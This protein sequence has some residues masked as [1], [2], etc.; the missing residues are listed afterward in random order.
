M[1]QNDYEHIILNDSEDLKQEFYIKSGKGKHAS[2]ELLL[3]TN[4]RIYFYGREKRLFM[5]SKV[6]RF[7]NLKAIYA[8]SRSKGR[9]SILLFFAIMFLVFFIGIHLLSNSSYLGLSFSIEPL[10]VNLG[11]AFG[12]LFLIAYI[13]LTEKII[14]LEYPGDNLVIHCNRMKEKNINRMFRLISSAIDES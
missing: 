11:E 3:L 6:S 2:K 10:I 5:R 13:F 7:V 8:G 9:Y 4:K 1:R 12:I 14:T